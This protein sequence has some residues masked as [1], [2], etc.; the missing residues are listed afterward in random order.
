[1]KLIPFSFSYFSHI[2]GKKTPRQPGP[3]F[4]KLQKLQN[5]TYRS[6][7]KN[8]K[9]NN[10]PVP[11]RARRASTINSLPTGFNPNGANSGMEGTWTSVSERWPT[12]QIFR[13]LLLFL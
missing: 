4:M 3:Q 13:S 9:T 7:G 10:C 11:D 12:W 8:V 6:G 1:M 2:L 5:S